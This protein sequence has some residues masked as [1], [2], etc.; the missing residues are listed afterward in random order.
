MLAELVLVTRLLGLVSGDYPVTIYV[1]PKVAR[2]DLLRDGQKV[3]TLHGAP[4]RTM[5]NF[6]TELIPQELT[7]VAYD[8]EER[9]VGRDTQ[10]VNLPRPSAEAAIDL[11]RDGE[12]VRATVQWQHIGAAKVRDV[13]WKLDGKSFGEGKTS[14]L[15]PSTATKNLHVIEAAVTFWDGVVASKERVFGGIFTEEMPTELTGA[16]V[17]QRDGAVDPATCFR[18]RGKT[19]PAVAVEKGDSAMVMFVRSPDPA[20]ARRAFR[21]VAQDRSRPRFIFDADVRIIWPTATRVVEKERLYSA[22]LFDHTQALKGKTGTYALL[23]SRGGP[24]QNHSRYADAVA[25]AG[26]YASLGARRRAVVLVI[27]NEKD[28]SVQNAG[29]VRRYLERIGVPLFVWSL[30]GAKKDVTDVWGQVVDV[31]SGAKLQKATQELGREL[32]RQRIAWLPLE[33]LDALR[34]EAVDGCGFQPLARP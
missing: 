20:A 7:A 24:K 34:V 11:R 28:K 12:G 6:G 21:S 8:S 14:V 18:L 25:V 15:L 10:L 31:S 33:P 23:T 5:V 17:H 16:L 19:I 9:E 27:G 32:E 13:Q 3:A 22:S 1:D 29:M 4:W 26:V 30:A 2:I